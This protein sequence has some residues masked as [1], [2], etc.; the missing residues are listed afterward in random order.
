M[1]NIVGLLTLLLV[2]GALANY[3]SQQ[4]QAKKYSSGVT[5]ERDFAIKTLDGI[6]NIVIK[7]ARLQPTQFQRKG[8]LWII[9]NKYEANEESMR[10]M[11]D[12]LTKMQLKYTPSK[13]TNATVKKDI[14]NSG[15]KVMLYAG[16]DKPFKTFYIASDNKDNDGTFMMMEGADQAFVMHLPG[17][18]GGF[19]SR[20]EQPLAK[21][22]DIY[23]YKEDQS[24]IKSITVQYLKSESSSF[25][26]SRVGETVK[27]EPLVPNTPIPT[28]PVN[29][30]IANKYIGYYASLGGEALLEKYELQDTLLQQIPFATVIVDRV[31]GSRHKSVFYVYEEFLLGLKPSRGPADLPNIE[32]YFMWV[33]N[34]DLYVSQNKIFRKIFLDFNDFFK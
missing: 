8:N 31:D 22:R 13:A 33:N 16:E 19:R 29:K 24:K 18:A 23:V 26:I 17:L 10:N 28:R 21:F 25:K 20:F 4:N 11:T 7:H 9:N 27:V 12:I 14:E 15:I 5:E 34:T 3:F 32:R 6:T 2:L 30:L 1:K